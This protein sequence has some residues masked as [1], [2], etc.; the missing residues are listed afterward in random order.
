MKL[1][2]LEDLQETDV[3]LTKLAATSVTPE[4]LHAGAA[5]A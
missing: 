3:K 1:N 2:S 4:A 5:K